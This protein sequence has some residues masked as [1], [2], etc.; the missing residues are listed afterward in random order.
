VFYDL[1]GIDAHSVL[2]QAVQRLS[3]LSP[4]MQETLYN[5]LI[6][7]ERLNSTGIGGGIALPHPRVPLSPELDHSM[8]A[9]FFMQHPVDFGALDDRPVFI[10]FMLLSTGVKAH[11]N[12][13]S[14]LSFCV[15]QQSFVHFLKSVPQPAA[16]FA[17]IAR[18]END[19]DDGVQDKGP[20]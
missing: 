12:L 8:I 19:L 4:S 10:L 1:P 14:R 17:D 2:H 20:H 16:L 3:W 5:R 7:R 6:D 11:L 9:T 18:F 13:L 15:R